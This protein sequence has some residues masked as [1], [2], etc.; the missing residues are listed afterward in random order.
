MPETNFDLIVIGAGPGGYTA[1]IR[2][3]QLGMRVACAERQFLGGTCLNI[4]CIPS[5]ALLDSSQHYHR[6]QHSLARRGIKVGQVSLDLPTM[7]GFKDEVVKKMSGGVGYLF[8]KNKIE[9]LVGQAKILAPGSVDVAGKKYAAKNILVAT[10]SAPIGLPSLPFD[11]KNILS[12][13]EALSIPA[14]PAKMIV[15]GAGYIGVELGSVWNRLGSEVTILEFLPGIL[16][17]SDR[18]MAGALQKSLEKQGIKFRLNTTAQ[19]A[20]IAGDKVKIAWKTG[21]ETGEDEVDKV[22]ICV[23][24]KPVTDGLGLAEVGVALDKKGFV[25]VDGHYATNVTGIYAIG[26]AIGGAMLAHKAE[27]EGVAAVESLA[28]KGGH[29]NY[30]ACPAVVYTHPELAQVGLTEE[31]ARKRGEVRI[32]KFNFAAN[33]RARGMDE[34]EG[35]VKVIGD[36]KTDRLL[37]VHILGAEAGTMIA[38]AVMAMEFAS[39]VEDV[40]RAFHAHPTMPEAI[41]EAAL[42]AE[43]RVRQ[44]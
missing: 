9:H 39:S 44:S 22:L 28:G 24:R 1:A 40:A 42:A 2:A 23:G 14:V 19:S 27:E 29:V 16:P 26:D 6:V 30:A 17:P 5:K 8:K 38:E 32:G 4:G 21:D 12:S 20:K 36:A 7:M 3:S 13:T 41:R 10:G 18:E 43:G 37:G 25:I 11:G 34:I 31:E 33:G 35:F 15:V